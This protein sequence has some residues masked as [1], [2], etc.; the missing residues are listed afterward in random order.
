MSAAGAADTAAAAQFLQKAQQF[1]DAA[2]PDEAAAEVG[3][4]RRADPGNPGIQE[5]TQAIEQLRKL[6][7]GKG[8]DSR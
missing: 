1:I 8:P 6:L 5:K 7:G 2:K 4:A 3:K